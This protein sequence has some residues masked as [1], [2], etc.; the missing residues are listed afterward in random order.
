MT[1]ATVTINLGQRSISVGAHVPT[2][3][4]LQTL[5]TRLRLRLNS[6][7]KQLSQLDQNMELGADQTRTISLLASD[8]DGVED[9][10]AEYSSNNHIPIEHNTNRP[11]LELARAVRQQPEHLCL[12]QPRQQ[13]PLE[14]AIEPTETRTPPKIVDQQPRAQE[15]P[16]E[17]QEDTTSPDT[18]S[19]DTTSQAD[20]R[21]AVS[22]TID[23]TVIFDSDLQARLFFENARWPNG[24]TCTRCPSH[25]AYFDKNSA[26]YRCEAC[27]QSFN[28]RTKTFMSNTRLNNAAWAVIMAEST[29]ELSKTDIRSLH[30]RMGIS[31]Y[32]LND[33]IR[34]IRG[35][36]LPTWCQRIIEKI[37]V[38]KANQRDCS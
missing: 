12:D 5:I 37:A 15:I 4:T 23:P 1:Q 13:K 28:V 9:L 24:I 27:R 38:I 21:P 36:D 25:K 29:R 7:D 33:A 19:P 8:I 3:N 17:A 26:S 18:T 31:I 22:Y 30:E 34:R 32:S 6:L 11:A 35:D 20:E 10:V 16:P 14:R 2:V